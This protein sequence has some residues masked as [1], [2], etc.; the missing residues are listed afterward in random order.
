MTGHGIEVVSLPR[1]V[2]LLNEELKRA[3]EYRSGMQFFIAGD[4][5]GHDLEAPRLFEPAR[6]ALRK[7]VFDRVAR[8]YAISS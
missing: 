1:F 6:F 5:S 7:L 8:T 4:R 3:P 2:E